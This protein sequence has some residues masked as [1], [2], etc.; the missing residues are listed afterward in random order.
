MTTTRLV[1][2]GAAVIIT[3]LALLLVW[4]LRLAVVYVLISLALAAAVRPLFRAWA[5]RAWPRR[6]GLLGL[7]LV[8]AAGV[9]VASGR[10]QRCCAGTAPA[11]MNSRL[12]IG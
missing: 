4:Q 8:A 7:C 10:L 2:S 5:G 11:S 12:I 6:L 3:L 9:C 1:T